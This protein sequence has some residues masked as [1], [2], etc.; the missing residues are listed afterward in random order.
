MTNKSKAKGTRGETRVVNYL[1]KHGFDAKRIALHG[2]KDMGDIEVGTGSHILEVKAGNQAKNVSRKKLEEWRSQTL[3][4]EANQREVTGSP[5]ISC[6]LIILPPGKPLKDCL[7]YLFK[8]P[9]D[10]WN[11]GNGWY[12]CIPFDSWV[13]ELAEMYLK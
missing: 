11:D 3:A 13:D 9:L 6:L 1:R 4:E 7:V 8:D 12:S 2:S 5:I 10:P